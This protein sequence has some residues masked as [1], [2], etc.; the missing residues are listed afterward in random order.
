MVADADNHEADLMN[1][2]A[3]C[4]AVQGFILVPPRT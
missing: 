1:P 2:L 3:L 4:V